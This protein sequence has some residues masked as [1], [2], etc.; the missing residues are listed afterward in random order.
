MV[1]FD[2]TTNFKNATIVNTAYDFYGKEHTSVPAPLDYKNLWLPELIAPFDA[3]VELWARNLGNEIPLIGIFLDLQMYH[4]QDKDDATLYNN[5]LDFSDHSWHIYCLDN[6]NETLYQVNN[7]NDR[8]KYLCENNKI[9]EY[10]A[11]L[12]KAAYQLGKMI[13]EHLHTRIPNLH[14]GVYQGAGLPEDWFHLGFLAGLST[15]KNPIILAT[16]N[17]NAYSHMEYLCD[18][19]IYC[20]HIP[21]MLMSK[22]QEEADF[23]LIQE[24]RKYHDGIWFSRFSHI[25]KDLVKDTDWWRLE[26]SLLPKDVIINQLAHYSTGSKI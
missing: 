19:G 1:N 21:S 24:R 20:F 13:R 12:Q 14:I 6:N 17:N 26:A 22:F 18:N 15:P 8:I 25:V 10:F 2:I 23:E 7:A 9:E 3:F 11:C 4:A 5:L 16:F